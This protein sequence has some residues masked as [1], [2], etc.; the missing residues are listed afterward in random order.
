VYSVDE[1]RAPGVKPYTPNRRQPL[2]EPKQLSGETGDRSGYGADEKFKKPDDKIKKPGTEV[3]PVQKYGRIFSNIPYGIGAHANRNRSRNSTIRGMDPGAPR[4][5]KIAPQE[6]KKPSREIVR[7][8]K[9]EDFELWVNNLLDEGYDLSGYT[10]EGLYEEYIQNEAYDI[11]DVI[12]SHL[13]NEGYADTF[14]AAE[15]IMVNM[16]E[17]WRESIVESIARGS[18]PNSPTGNL[19]GLAGDLLKKGTDFIKKNIPQSGGTSTMPG[20]GKPYKDGPL[21][22]SNQ[23]PE[24]VKNTPTSKPT[25]RKP[26]PSM[27]D[28]PLW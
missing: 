16:S 1:E 6:K 3:P 28:E 19:G 17:E 9:K 8:T 20:D 4:S 22:D 13:I 5:E 12:L 14:E 2:P 18:A 25:V 15:A 11:Y 10:W 27:R 26:N 7:K 24:D 21:W 23:K